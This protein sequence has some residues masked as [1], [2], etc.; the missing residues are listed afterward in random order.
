MRHIWLSL[1]ALLFIVMEGMVVNLLPPSLLFAEWFIIPHWTLVFLLLM[2]IYFDSSETY[3]SLW[4]A[5]VS[6]L[7]IDIIYTDILGV[8]M[9]VYVIVVYIIHGVN[10]LL[11]SN[12]LVVALLVLTGVAMA[13]TLLYVVYSFLNLTDLPWGTYAGN[14]LWPTLLANAIVFLFISLFL[15]NVMQKW[16]DDD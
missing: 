9:M 13:D 12:L 10:K 8:H 4:Y 7:F 3:V 6:G 5:L 15:K 11:Q 1:L 16:A 2:S 14:R